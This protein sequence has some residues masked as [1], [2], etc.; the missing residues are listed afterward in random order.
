VVYE[1]VNN[2]GGSY[3]HETLYDFTCSDD[4]GNPFGGVV[5]DSGGNLYGTAQHNGAYGAGVV[6]ELVNHGDGSYEFEVIHSF[7]KGKGGGAF[8]VGNLV[9]F[10]GSLHGVTYGGGGGNCD[11]GCGAV[12]RLS[13]SGGKWVET[14]L[15]VFKDRADGHWPNAGVV[16]DSAGNIYG[17]TSLGGSLGYGI[18]FKLS[19]QGG[20]V[21]IPS[22]ES[23]GSYK[24]TIL[25]SFDGAG[26]GCYLTSG[27]IVDSVGNL[28]GTALMCGDYGDGTVYQLKH[29]GSKYQFRVIL[30]FNGTN[31]EYPYNET[32]NLALD[33][34]GN[35]Y[36]TAQEGGAHSEGTV[37][38]LAAGSFLYTDLHDF[39]ND[40]KDGYSP[41][42]GVSLDSLGELYGTTTLGGSYGYGTVWQIANP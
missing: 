16:V 2:G 15:H 7:S 25:H 1:L 37:F 10:K 23:S 13:K 20:S 18:V 28:Y 22:D 3:T 11:G 34:A 21:E 4:G 9:R 40:G 5:M 19:S 31:G 38:K 41:S 35:V 42:G 17:T 24:E 8:P 33:S 12:Y 30:S 39:N 6:Y 14:V 26:D 27:L 32:S 29:S 36:G